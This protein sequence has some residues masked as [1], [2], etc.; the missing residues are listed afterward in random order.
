MVTDL[1]AQIAACLEAGGAPYSLSAAL[2]RAIT[3]LGR[4]TLRRQNIVIGE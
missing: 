2:E 3:A 4:L 1:E